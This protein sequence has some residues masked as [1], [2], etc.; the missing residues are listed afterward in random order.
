MPRLK[1]RLL[2]P[3][4][5]EQAGAACDLHSHKAL[6][7]LIYLAV[8]NQPHSRAKLATLFWPEQN[9]SRALAYLRHT[10]WK[11]R[12]T[13]G[14]DLFDS[15]QELVSLRS[16]ADLWVDVTVFQA[17]LDA[18]RHTGEMT[19]EVFSAYLPQLRA[20]VELYHDD[21]L[22]GFSL[23][24]S[25]TFDDWQFFQSEHLRQQLATA[26]QQL[27]QGHSRR[28]EY[29]LALPYAR[30]WLALDPLHEPAHQCLMQLFAWSG[31]RAAAV[32]QYQ[33]CVRILREELAV[34]PDAETTQLF[35][36]IQE[37]R[38]AGP[39]APRSI[40]PTPQTAPPADHAPRSPTL[41]TPIPDEVRVVTILCAGLVDLV[42]QHPEPHIEEAAGRIPGLLQAA[43]L[44]LVGYQAYVE[45]G[46]GDT[47]LIVFGARQMHEDDAE[48]GLRAA[49]ELQTL[50]RQQA[51]RLSIGVH[52]GAVLART[53]IRHT[54]RWT[55]MGE[56]VMGSVV[57]LATR[58]QAQ[59]EAGDILV[60]KAVYRQTR[61]AFDFLPVVLT[62]R[63]AARPL[64]A[65]LLTQ[66]RLHPEKARGVEDLRTTLVGRTAE[67]GQLQ[68]RMAQLHQ[69][70]GHLVTLIGDAGVGK[71][72]LIAELKQSFQA[73]LRFALTD[74]PT[75]SASSPTA[76]LGQHSA[77]RTPHSAFLWLEGRAQEFAQSSSY[78]PWLDL[79]RLYLGWQPQDSEA[80][81]VGRLTTALHQL[82]GQGALTVAQVNT[83]T[84]LLGRLLGL[85]QERTW[86]DQDSEQLHQ[87]TLFAMRDLLIALAQAQPLVLVLEDLHWADPL[88]LELVVLIMEALAQQP[89]LLLCVY[90][91]EQEH[92]VWQLVA[93]A[94]RKCPEHYIELALRELTPRQSRLLVTALL[95]APDLAPA[96]QDF[97]LAKAQ[98]NPL[99]L[100][101]LIHTLIELGVLYREAG[102]WRA[103]PH[104]T[105][106]AI[107]DTLQ[108]LI[109]ARV[110]RLPSAL[111]QV[112]QCAAVIGPLFGEALLTALVKPALS[113]KAML[114]AALQ[115]L[116]ARA[117]VYQ[118][119]V[120]PEVSYAFRHVLVQEA[121]YSSLLPSERQRLHHF[122][123]ETL[124]QL[125]P[126]PDAEQVVVL[127]HH[128]ERAAQPAKAIHYLQ[129]TGD[130]ARLAY[131]HP[132]AIHCYRR[133]LELML[134]QGDYE[135]AARTYMKLGLTQQNAADYAAA[136][137]TFDEGF[138]LWQKAAQR[139]QP[140]TATPTRTLRLFYGEPQTLDP[141]TAGDENSE[142]IIRQCYSG[143]V[144]LT[145]DLNIVP[146]VAQSWHVL[147]GGRTYL[148]RL[149]TDVYWSDGTPVT[150]HD[151]VYAW[152][153]VLDPVAGRW[154]GRGLYAIRGA[155]AWHNNAVSDPNTLGCYA[156][157]NY[158]LVVELE[159][160][161]SYFL[162]LLTQVMALPVP[163]HLVEKAGQGWTQPGQLVTNG[164]FLLDAWQPGQ[165]LTLVRNPRYHGA[166]QGNIAEVKL[167]I[168]G[169]PAEALQ[170]YAVGQLDVLPLADLPAAD[171]ALVRR[172]HVGEYLSAP[173][174]ATIFLSLNFNRPPFADCHL[175]RAFAHA[176]DR[177][178]LAGEALGG[179]DFPAAGVLPAGL[180]GYAPDSG[181][182][183]D[184][185]QARQ[186]LAACGYPQG[187]GFPAITAWAWP[188]IA[189]I[190]HAL[191]RQWQEALGI[192]VQ[193]QYLA[194]PE[195][196]RIGSKSLPDL[197]IYGFV[198]DYPDPDSLLRLHFSSASLQTA[199]A[200]YNQLLAEAGRIPDQAQRLH[201][202]RQADRLLCAEAPVIPLL[203]ERLH[204]LVKPWVRAFPTSAVRWSFWKDVVLDPRPI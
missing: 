174:L 47:F 141:A 119:R 163:R 19:A 81:K 169:T 68:Q 114:P 165:M 139:G 109:L 203:Y 128:W 183:Y 13:L 2:G 167:H 25:A 122:V 106:L 45:P 31:Q 191:S 94:S 89:I 24:D 173:R 129:Q 199:Q 184:P 196:T 17:H 113:D 132:E 185:V 188:G 49:C 42:E 202:Y 90:R 149:R 159:N 76:S 192:D 59:G 164:P 33:E 66:A 153:R 5:V 78:W 148:F 147:H 92:K 112:V 133:A 142:E 126:E 140:T 186:L 86:E 152:R 155:A 157:D 23:R 181:L 55:Q 175:R 37:N 88:S 161:T 27:V 29:A 146:D 156:R 200:E 198:M 127:A 97:I 178:K 171:R 72:R 143:L 3:P 107:P 26:L 50:A 125:G 67:L 64:T 58:L 134:A 48:R 54:E 135:P 189:P 93:L 120:T 65:Y 7:L 115:Q 103:Q 82:L 130:R 38:L 20:A 1:L 46:L 187:D 105:T 201:L 180:P 194:W 176:T 100:E 151:F 10:L 144:D 95:V 69:G 51:L 91:P 9:E 16:T 21:F 123:A 145:P 168:G 39:G 18:C 98:G 84:P 104:L 154:Q 96:A 136:R 83:L 177:I 61:G 102:Q 75:A 121:V 60:S 79:L 111:R 193:W 28:R 138:A 117:F 36:A 108:N 87:Q 110:E 22:A 12:T 15:E 74:F 34:P 158:T 56:L 131:A 101:E 195:F 190:C 182:S 14:D 70:E 179:Y 85:G 77:F 63:G 57:N 73:D 8:T 170:H 53:S 118:E 124:E 160:P 116:T 197:F 204:L 43:N 35:Q 62:L 166:R 162:A 32:R 40:D 52:T 80:T 41:P 172:R 11:L 44:F 99:F 30:R 6:A 137:R 71:S 150:A 4:Q